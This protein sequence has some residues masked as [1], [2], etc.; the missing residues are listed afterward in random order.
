MVIEPTYLPQISICYDVKPVLY[1]VHAT[2]RQSFNNSNLALQVLWHLMQGSRLALIDC[3]LDMTF[4]FLFCL[5]CIFNIV[6][7]RHLCRPVNN[8]CRP[9]IEIIWHWATLI[10]REIIKIVATK[11]HI[12][13]LK[14]TKFNFG[15]GSAP[16]PARGSSQ[17]SPRL[18]S[19][20]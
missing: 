20:I 18:P 1:L 10:F 19:W 12:L 2:Q 13:R 4:P 5:Q 17:R 9:V 3:L 11:C 8:F 14:C 16:D 7:G 15:W 6:T